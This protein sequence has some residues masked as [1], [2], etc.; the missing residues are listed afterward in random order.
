MIRVPTDV[1]SKL[2]LIFRLSL[3][4]PLHVC[5]NEANLEYRTIRIFYRSKNFFCFVLQIGTCNLL[6]YISSTLSKFI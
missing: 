1:E 5:G 3:I 6:M 2:Q 4:D